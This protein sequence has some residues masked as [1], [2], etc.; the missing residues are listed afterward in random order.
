MKNDSPNLVQR[1]RSLDNGAQN[2]TL[3]SSSSGGHQTASRKRDR[4]STIRAS[5]YMIKPIA[6][7][8]GSGEISTGVAAL[9]T[10]TRSGTIRQVRPPMASSASGF[11]L[12]TSQSYTGQ[13]QT[14][15]G[16]TYDPLIL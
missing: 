6:S 7:V 10:R 14:P 5:D 16:I 4:A 3:P 12:A 2:A 1:A 15:S 8:L 13:R 11:P 9:T